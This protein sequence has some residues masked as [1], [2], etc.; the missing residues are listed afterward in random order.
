MRAAPLRLFAFALLAAVAACGGQVRWSKAGADEASAGSELNA[1]RAAAHSAV[2]RMYGVPTMSSGH[3]G[4]FGG[5]TNDPSLADRQIRE[6]EAVN[7]CMR[8]KGYTLVPV[9]G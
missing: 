1:C 9:E 2:Q 7:R 4:P 3:Q 8:E 6:Q 5:S